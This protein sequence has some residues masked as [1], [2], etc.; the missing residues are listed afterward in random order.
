[1]ELNKREMPKKNYNRKP[2]LLG[3]NDYDIYLFYF[4]IFIYILYILMFCIF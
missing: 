4:C 3:I 2:K 1:M